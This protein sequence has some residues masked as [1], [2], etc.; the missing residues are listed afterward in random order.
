MIMPS[1]PPDYLDLFGTR[2]FDGG[3]PSL[4]DPAAHL[5]APAGQVFWIDPRGDERALVPLRDGD[6]KV[7]RP[8]PPE[9]DIQ[10]AAAFA[11]RY[12]FSPYQGEA[13]QFRHDVVGILRLFHHI[14]GLSPQPEHGRP[15]LALDA[16]KK[17]QTCAIAPTCGDKCITF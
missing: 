10:H 2:G 12:H 16:A 1:V 7:L 17:R 13:S 9:I 8:A 3:P 11:D 15:R 6:G 14:I 4:F 5:D